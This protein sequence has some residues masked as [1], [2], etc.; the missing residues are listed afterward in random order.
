MEFGVGFSDMNEQVLFESFAGLSK[1]VVSQNNKNDVI[2][3]GLE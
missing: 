2:N 3:G 1:F